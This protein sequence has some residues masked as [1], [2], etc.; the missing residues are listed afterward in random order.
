MGLPDQRFELVEFLLP[1][2]LLDSRLIPE[3]PIEKMVGAIGKTSL[4]EE[5][6]TRPASISFLGA[7]PSNG[8]SRLA[9]TRSCGCSG[10]TPQHMTAKL[11]TRTGS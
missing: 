1:A 5:R 10:G 8:K 4:N 11:I 6:F 2:E 9:T 7:C 3:S